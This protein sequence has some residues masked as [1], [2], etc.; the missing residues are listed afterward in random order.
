MQPRALPSESAGLGLRRALAGSLQ[1][2]AAGSFD[3]LEAAPENWIGVGGRYGR[4]L[5]ALAE[6]HP[7]VCHGL[8]LSLGGP[9]PLDEAFLHRVR[10]FLDA[11]RVPLYSEHLSYCSDDGHLYDLMPIP[12]TAEAVRHDDERDTLSEHE[13]ATD[14]QRVACDLAQ[15]EGASR[16]VL[17]DRYSRVHYVPVE[18]NADG[19]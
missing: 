19:R 13:S 4:M 9:E 6:R 2:A 17:H 5:A 7:L 8:S 1:D 12:F 14:A 3:F 10:R 18:A 15:I 16:V 11:H